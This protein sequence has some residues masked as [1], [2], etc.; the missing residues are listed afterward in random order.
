MQQYHE[1]FVYN[2]VAVTVVINVF[3]SFES[4]IFHGSF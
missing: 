2:L 1:K 3:L 4:N